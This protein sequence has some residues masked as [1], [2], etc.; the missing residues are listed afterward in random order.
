MN[1]TD[2]NNSMIEV[3]NMKLKR[4]I[5]KFSFYYISCQSDFDKNQKW[6]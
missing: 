4:V 2:F 3:T 5:Q 1:F 6:Y